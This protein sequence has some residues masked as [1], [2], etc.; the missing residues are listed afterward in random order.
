MPNIS[1]IVDASEEFLKEIRSATPGNTQIIRKKESIVAD[2]AN[3]LVVWT[4]DQTHH[5][6]FFSQS[7]IQNKALNHQFYE[8]QVKRNA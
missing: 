2:M 6:I 1:Q 8:G 7:L 3:V 5:N 4:E